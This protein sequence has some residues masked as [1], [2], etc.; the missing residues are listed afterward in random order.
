MVFSKWRAFA[1]FDAL[2]TEVPAK[3]QEA[4]TQRP[5]LLTIS[6]AQHTIF[7]DGAVPIRF[8]HDVV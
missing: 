6:G 7:D 4:M 2:L 1:R 5:D 8:D 3:P